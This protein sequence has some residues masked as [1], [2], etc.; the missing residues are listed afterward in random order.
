MVTKLNIP[1][2]EDKIRKLKVGDIVKITGTIFTMRDAAQKYIFD[3]NKPPVE[4][5]NSVIYHCG[6]IIRKENNKWA[7]KAAGPTTSARGEPYVP[8]LI[9]KFG[10]RGII[11]KGGMGEDT[12]K[13]CNKFGAV[14]LHATGGASQVLASKITAVKNIYWEDKFG[15][16]EAIWELEVKDFPAIVTMDSHGNNLHREVLDLS[17][18]NLKKL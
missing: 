13:A 7:V 16:P 12:L 15:A 1:I 6:P 9:K 11:G 18:S 10:I 14:Y 4:L 8:G 17:R 2:N 5:N 3:G